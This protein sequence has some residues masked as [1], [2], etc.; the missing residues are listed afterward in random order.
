MLTKSYTSLRRPFAF[1][2]TLLLFCV[3]F[4]KG[5]GAQATPPVVT[6]S[7]A[8]SL[9]APSGLGTVYQTA[10]DSNGDLLVMDYSIG[11]L[12]EYPAGGGAV[13]TLVAPGGLGGYANPG[14]AI[15]SNNNLYIEANYKFQ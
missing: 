7:F 13:V 4:G 6:G 8:T 5:A 15:D 3:T 2:L 10:L 9:T 12:Y 14:I 11:S 1:A